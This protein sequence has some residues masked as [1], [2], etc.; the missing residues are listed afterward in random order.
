MPH[1]RLHEL[2]RPLQSIQR[3]TRW[4]WLCR[5]VCYCQSIQLKLLTAHTCSHVG[6]LGN[7]DADASGTANFTLTDNVISLTGITSVVGRVLVVRLL[8][9]T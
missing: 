3:D 6:D 4:T 9:M 1:N 2:W 7:I 5:S 8:L